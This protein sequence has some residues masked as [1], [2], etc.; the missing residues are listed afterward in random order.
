MS[1]VVIG[2][3]SGPIVSG[4]GA[5]TGTYQAGET[6]TVSTSGA[7]GLYMFHADVDGFGTCDFNT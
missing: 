1:L 7:S 2:S 5:I 3:F 6:L 4:T